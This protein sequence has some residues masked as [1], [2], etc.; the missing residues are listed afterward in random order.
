LK[1]GFTIVQASYQSPLVEQADVVLP[2]P[3]WYERPAT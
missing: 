1:A 3:I 2:A